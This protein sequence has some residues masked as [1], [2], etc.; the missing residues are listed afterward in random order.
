VAVSAI[1]ALALF[2]VFRGLVYVSLPLGAGPF[3]S[4]TVWIV[5]LLG[6]R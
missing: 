3:H 1:G 6:M 5:S 2:Y 4:A